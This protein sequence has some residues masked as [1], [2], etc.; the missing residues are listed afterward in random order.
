MDE[1]S[2][3]KA[4][5]SLGEIV[6]RAR[7]AGT[8]TMITRQGKPAAV[9]VSAEWYERT[10]TETTCRCGA[11]LELLAGKTILWVDEHISWLCGDGKPHAP[12]AACASPGT[13]SGHQR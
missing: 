8:P 2:I 7:L 5:P 11:K 12:V 4:R 13:D 3:E 9:I 10:T 6:D 1:I